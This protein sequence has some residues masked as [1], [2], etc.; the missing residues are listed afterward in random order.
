MHSPRSSRVRRVLAP[1]AAATALLAVLP[2]GQ[3]AA[4]GINGDNAGVSAGSAQG[5]ANFGASLDKVAQAG[6]GWIRLSCSWTSSYDPGTRQWNWAGCDNRVNA[7]TSRGI[8][9]LILSYYS[10]ATDCH[11]APASENSF[12]ARETYPPCSYTR[13]YDFIN[14]MVARYGSQGTGQV[15]A[16][17]IGN[18]PNYREFFPAFPANSDAATQEYAKILKTAHDAAKAADPNAVVLNGGLASGGDQGTQYDPDFL[19][20]ILNDGQNPA[21][22]NF[23]VLNFHTYGNPESSGKALDRWNAQLGG[24]SKP[25]WATEIGYASERQY[26]EKKQF[27][28]E[29]SPGE[30]GQAEYLTDTIPFLRTRG[31]AKVFWS[32]QLDATIDAGFFCSH[33]LM[34]TTG[35]MCTGGGSGALRTK[36]S[37]DAYKQLI[38][39]GESGNGGGGD[40]RGGGSTPPPAATSCLGLPAT[41][42]GTEGDDLIRGTDGADVIVAGS[43]KDRI[44]GLTGSDV[45]C[46]GNGRDSVD[47]AG[48]ADRVLGEA[49][50][51]AVEGSNGD[52]ILKGN[53]G[54]DDLGGGRGDDKIRGGS[55]KD[56]V[57][58]GGGDNST[59]R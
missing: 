36:L 4:A 35:A 47:A 48:G 49:G 1:I 37:Y 8:K 21:G 5:D 27:F 32:T 46:A 51:D 23:E 43:G 42:V 12:S 31:V 18:E 25:A 15:T 10:H 9:P 38:V 17:E 55:G 39:N 13:Y 29:Y 53:A 59:K 58:G 34:Y 54:D 45:I 52:D 11:T 41:T 22:G 2:A 33:G 16:W 50:D 26:Q 28:T 24:L 44:K 3:A 14:R 19:S 56:K 57:D 20:N 7:A 30:Q 6:I 40:T